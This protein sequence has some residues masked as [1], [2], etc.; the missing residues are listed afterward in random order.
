MLDFILVMGHVPGT[1]IDITFTEI[2]IGLPLVAAAIYWHRKNP[3][4]FSLAVQE[5]RDAFGHLLAATHLKKA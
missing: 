2:I 3:S 1:N 5:T 4:V